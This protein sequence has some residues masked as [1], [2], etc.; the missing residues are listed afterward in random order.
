MLQDPGPDTAK[1]PATTTIRITIYD[2]TPQATGSPSPNP[3]TS[4]P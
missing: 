1:D 3:T 4:G 2:Y